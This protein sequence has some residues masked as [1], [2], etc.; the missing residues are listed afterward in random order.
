MAISWARP[1]A[2]ESFSPIFWPLMISRLIVSV[3]TASASLACCGVDMVK[4]NRTGVNA[5]M[6]VGMYSSGER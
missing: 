1:F 5:G 6:E 4:S 2:A 3:M